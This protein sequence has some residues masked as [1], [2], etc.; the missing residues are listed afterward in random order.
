[1]ATRSIIQKADLV[2]GAYYLGLCRNT[3]IAQWTGS[4][5]VY[6]RHKLGH[7]FLENIF[8]PEDDDRYDVFLPFKKIDLSELVEWVKGVEE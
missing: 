2:E 6:I 3:N 1:M 5:F 7:R 4:D 8:H